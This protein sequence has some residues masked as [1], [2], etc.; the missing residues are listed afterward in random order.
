MEAENMKMKIIKMIT[1]DHFKETE[2]ESY[3]LKLFGDLC[4]KPKYLLIMNYNFF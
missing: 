1:E 2:T 4:T 3:I